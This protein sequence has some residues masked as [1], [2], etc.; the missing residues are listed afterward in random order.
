MV[1]E[2]IGENEEVA[3][4]FPK[5]STFRALVEQAPDMVAVVQA[6]GTIAYIN[7]A[8]KR[9]LGY[10]PQERVGMSALEHV[11]PEDRERLSQKLAEV[12]DK[13]H[14]TATLECRFQHKDGSWRALE[15]VGRYMATDGCPACIAVYTRDITTRKAYEDEL[16]RARSVAEEMNLIKT[17][18]LENV[19]HEL[20]T[21]LTG[22][23]GSASVLR[24]EVPHPQ[25]DLVGLI[26]KSG[27][28]LLE[29]V[30]GLLDL[31]LLES[32]TLKLNVE[33]V[34]V[35]RAVEAKVHALEYIAE[36]QD[37][38]LTF[39]AET[40][41]SWAALDLARLNRIV[42][43]LVGNAIKFSDTGHIYV[44]VNEEQG[45]VCMAVQD[46]G[47]G[48]SEPFLQKMFEAFYQ[49]STGD[50]RLYEG[51]GLGLT[52]TKH[53]AHK[54]GGTISVQS[55]KGA[56]STFV[57]SFPKAEGLLP[58]P[59]AATATYG[60]QRVLVVDD[61][62]DTCHLIRYMLT[63]KTQ[64]DTVST[65]AQAMERAQAGRYDAVLLDMELG[66]HW[67]T[68]VLGNL[69]TL[70]DYENVP[71]IALTVYASLHHRRRFI[72][73]GFDDYLSKPFSK[74][75]LLRV[76]GLFNEHESQV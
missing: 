71:I 35:V 12:L 65:A 22:I 47:V 28:R 18:F 51:M 24:E 60:P 66:R 32:G 56:G 2:F 34:D 64:V 23:L 55:Q 46:E 14:D 42:E 26:T 38:R 68:D 29:T 31:A 7:A 43:S 45:R 70:P 50:A 75:S 30:N 48:I 16:K 53:L 40:P 11:H 1:M 67:E 37:L 33:V 52:I 6:D 73:E 36:E 3:L 41:Q 44:R 72:Q 27:E 59:V 21:P 58:K 63:G 39:E 74:E 4:P 54:M 5:K 62:P 19:S 61:D 10:H 49:E 13:P 9:M 69:R 76:L 8:V 17:A 20:R 57:V 25:R 15:S